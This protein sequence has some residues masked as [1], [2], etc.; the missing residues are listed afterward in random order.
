MR[1]LC[2]VSVIILLKVVCVSAQDAEV[3][4]KQ[5]KIKA[6]AIDSIAGILYRGNEIN[7]AIDTE[8]VALQLW[9]ESG[10]KNGIANAYSFIGQLYEAKNENFTAL[11]YYE[12]STELYIQTGNKDTLGEVY[13][14]IALIQ[15]YL[16]Q[17]GDALETN[18]KALE[19]GRL[20]KDTGLITRTLLS[21]GFLYM[22]A[23]KFPLAYKNQLEALDIFQAR[24]DSLGIATVYSDLAL[25][26]TREKNTDAAL[27]Y[28]TAA[29]AIRKQI[30]HYY[31]VV[32]SCIYIS[33]ILRRQGKY[34]EA[35]V[36]NMEA[37]QYAE[38]AGDVESDILLDAGS[39]YKEMGDWKNA[40]LNFEALL[41][42]NKK[43][44]N[45]KVQAQALQYIASVFLLQGKTIPAIASLKEAAAVADTSDF[46]NLRYIYESL[47]DIYAK[48]GDYKNAYESSLKF[49]A[50]SDSV[51]VR[52]KA[53]KVASITRQL[54]YDNMKAMLKLNQ[55]KQL[56]A[57]QAIIER[58]KLLRNITIAGLLVVIVLA[59]IFF[60]RFREKRKLNITLGQTLENLKATQA[61]L[62]QSEK[63]ASL[64]ELTAG[65][66]HEIQN[67]LNFVNNF[68]EV[69]TELIA[70]MKAEID[71][72]DLDEVKAIAN[73]IADNE[74]K[75]LHHGRRADAIVKGMLQH[76]RS[77]SGVKEPT[78]I[79]ALADEYLR[80]AY[81]GLRAKDKSFNATLK[82]D[83]DA[84]IGKVNV[85]PQDIGRVI[86]NLITNAFYAVAEKERLLT[87]PGFQTPAALEDIPA[88]YEPTVTVSTKKTGNTIE[89]RVTDNGNGIPA[90]IVDKIFQPF[91][92]TKPTGQGTGLGLSLSYDIVKAHGG[93]LKVETMEGNGS[94]F[95][96][97]LPG[98]GI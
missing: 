74:Q 38:Q 94:E 33:A 11:K 67:P 18:M 10:D 24:R 22:Y 29:L 65:I 97:R 91:F 75:I 79:N 84:S 13:Y 51:A 72:G 56:A 6:K 81:H 78:D 42:V 92:T 40:L 16:Q 71:E 23:K 17:Y 63:M 66:A 27:K 43:S 88:P 46:L 55:D 83:Y 1:N 90:P 34:K 21:N 60:V 73:D 62:I 86:L 26:Y 89:I 19:I 9:I 82:T 45:R 12:S 31:G 59:V 52:E 58:Q 50:F 61:Q 4:Q 35:L 98:P 95:L 20:V 5:K 14:S 64:G 3:L 57:Q 15:R 8:K 96:I 48:A 80:L 36:Y 39:I 53:D 54:E 70:E 85:A 30:N 77:S 49:K 28:H 76:S 32:N 69:N 7:M 44:N 25:V 87:L 68:S 93:E 37:R 47:S 2:W 41:L